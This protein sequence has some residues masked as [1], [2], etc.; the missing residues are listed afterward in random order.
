MSFSKGASMSTGIGYH[1]EAVFMMQ[2]A[3]PQQRLSGGAGRSCSEGEGGSPAGAGGG[4]PPE[5]HV[6]RPAPHPEPA[7]ERPRVA[8][9]EQRG[10]LI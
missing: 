7:S 1:L 3:Q 6:W 5:G 4:G 2:A 9:A 10:R 8:G